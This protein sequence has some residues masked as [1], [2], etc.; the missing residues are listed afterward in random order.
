VTASYKTTQNAHVGAVVDDAVAARLLGRHVVGATDDDAVLRELT[1]SARLVELGDA[2]IDE[3][4]LHDITFDRDEDVVGL[5]VT[6]D[7]ALRMCGSQSVGDGQQNLH[8]LDAAKAQ[9]A[10]EPRCET[11]AVEKLHDDERIVLVGLSDIED[12]NDRRVTEARRG[13]RF[14]LQ[15]HAERFAIRFAAD[16]LDGDRRIEGDVVRR[17]HRPHSAFTQKPFEAILRRNHVTRRVGRARLVR[18]GHGGGLEEHRVSGDKPRPFGF[19][20]EPS[21]LHSCL[22]RRCKKHAHFLTRQRPR[23][24]TLPHLPGEFA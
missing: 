10:V 2:E 22:Q 19:R 12:S 3:L 13:A 17:P 8:G 6:V 11:L 21:T 16:H 14:E 20:R 7:D 4:R 1:R 5:D 15:T 18:L 24:R 9:L 23:W